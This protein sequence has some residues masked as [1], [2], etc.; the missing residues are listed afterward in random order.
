MNLPDPAAFVYVS[1]DRQDSTIRRILGLGFE[2]ASHRS[3]DSFP[4]DVPTKVAPGTWLLS[5]GGLQAALP[6][7]FPMPV[8]LLNAWLVKR[9]VRRAVRKLGFEECVLWMYWWFF[10][11]LAGSLGTKSVY[12]AVDR[13]D[14]YYFNASLP[15]LSR[16]ARRLEL[17]TVRLVDLV[18]SVSPEIYRRLQPLARAAIVAPNG[19]DLERIDK[20]LGEVQDAPVPAIGP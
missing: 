18:V 16:L 15:F 17:R 10:P 12:D 13:H 1:R 5:L 8:R 7:S 6:L 11:R 19:V 9:K 4:S 3:R 2:D 14:S 20:I